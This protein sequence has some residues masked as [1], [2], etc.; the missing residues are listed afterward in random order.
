MREGW[1]G[2]RRK[3]E[4]RRGREKERFTTSEGC[5]R[6]AGLDG[7]S[8][9]TTVAV[10]VVVVVVDVH[11]RSA[12]K[13][14]VVSPAAAPVAAP[15]PSR[16]RSTPCLMRPCSRSQRC[17]SARRRTGRQGVGR[18]PSPKYRVGSSSAT[19]YPSFRSSC[20]ACFCAGPRVARPPC[21]RPV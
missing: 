13:R 15:R 9:T 17:P 19:P 12:T 2:E 7:K 4:K 10:V 20:P 5:A 14:R 16:D 3:E 21:C 8:S 6:S 18:P 11:A 1:E